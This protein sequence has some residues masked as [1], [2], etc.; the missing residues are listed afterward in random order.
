[1]ATDRQLHQINGWITDDQEQFELYTRLDGRGFSYGAQLARDARSWK[2]WIF[3]LGTVVCLAYG[4][5]SND[6]TATIAGLALLG[7]YLFM[8]NTVV[9]AS[10]KAKLIEAVAR[11]DGHHPASHLLMSGTFYDPKSGARGNAILEEWAVEMFKRPDGS[12]PVLISY[13]SAAHTHPVVGVRPLQ[14]QPAAGA[15]TEGAHCAWHGDAAAVATCVRCGSFVCEQCARPH[16]EGK[17]CVECEGRR[18]VPVPVRL[19]LALGLA[20]AVV[21]VNAVSMLLFGVRI[22]YALAPQLALILALSWT[23]RNVLRRQGVELEPAVARAVTWVL[24]ADI[25]VMFAALTFIR[26][27]MRWWLHR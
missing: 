20:V 21:P 25:A 19:Y 6:R 23:G 3:W 1:V 4:T 15:A 14:W 5:L 22:T 27:L 11:F 16:P 13:S 18:E 2:P 7:T 8:L 12:V 17:L 26:P 9:R 24:G 10:G